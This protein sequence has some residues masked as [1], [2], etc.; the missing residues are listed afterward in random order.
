[1]K[2]TVLSIILVLAALCSASVARAQN[3][4]TNNWFLEVRLGTLNTFDNGKL[5]PFSPC[6]QIFGGR[7]VAP[8]LGFR[9]GVQGFLC[10]PADD[11]STWFS[12]ESFFGL[13]ALNADCLWNPFRTFNILKGN[14]F[15]N[16]N[17]YLRGS[18]ILA[19]SFGNHRKIPALGGGFMNL[20]N[21][22]D[23]I[24]VSLDVSALV[25]KERRFRN[26]G[27]GSGKAIILPSAT[28]GIYV[29]LGI[30]TY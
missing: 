21:V 13:Y 6:L 20:F 26:G 25:A 28:V 19:T 1:M 11:I 17:V 8:G 9:A 4:Y 2:K 15:I 30:T 10:Q 16:P 7:W 29:N 27:A 23:V 24:S 18:A 12:G 14:R 3:T 22:N 5:S